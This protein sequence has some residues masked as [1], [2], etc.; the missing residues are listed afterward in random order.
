MKAKELE[1]LKVRVLR[2]VSDNPRAPMGEVARY[3]SKEHKEGR[4]RRLLRRMAENRLIRLNCTRSSQA[5]ECV[6]IARGKAV[7]EKADVGNAQTH[8]GD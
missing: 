3:F 5:K 2:Y 4:I 8:K 7:L 1:E 6:I